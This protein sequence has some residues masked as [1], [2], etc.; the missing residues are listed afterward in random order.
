[1]SSQAEAL[2]QVVGFFQVREAMLASR[3]GRA[4]HVPTLPAPHAARPLPVA[5]KPALPH[6]VVKPKKNGTPTTEG[7]G[8][9]QR[10]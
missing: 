10:F 7:G 8:G 2:L 1:M 5:E 6:P 9:F 4:I 3:G